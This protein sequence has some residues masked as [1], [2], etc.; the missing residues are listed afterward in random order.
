MIILGLNAY[1]GDA[2]ACIMKDGKILFALEE[3]RIRRVKHW[4]GLPTEA[5]KACLAFTQIEFT[6]IDV[7]TISRDPKAKLFEKIKFAA[8]KI[9]SLKSIKN[10]SNNAFTISTLKEDILKSLGLN[11]AKAKVVFV[12]HHRCHLASSFYVSPFQKSALL[13][14]DGFGDFSS[15][16]WGIGEGVNINVEDSISYPHSLGVFYSTMTQLLGFDHFGDEYKVMGLAAYGEAKYLDRLLKIIQLKKVG[17]FQLEGKYFKHFS[18]GIKLQTDNEAPKISQL[19][20]EELQSL[21]AD[22][23]LDKELNQHHKDLA[24]STQVL[25]E[26]VI[27]EMA[28]NL[29]K[30]TGEKNLC[31]SGGVAQNSVAN[32]KLLK[33]TSFENIY[34]PPASYD[35]G[36]A[37]GSA[38]FY[39]HQI[40]GNSFSPNGHFKATLGPQFSN[41]EIIDQAQQMGLSFEELPFELINEKVTDCIAEGGVVGWFQG[42]TEF[43]PRALGNRSILADPRRKDIR[44]ILNLKIKN[45]ELFRPF[46]VSV[47]E[48]KIEDYFHEAIAS[49]YMERVF[50]VQENHKN[51]IPAATHADG[52]CRIQT[53]SQKEHPTFHN[54]ISLFHKKTKIPMLINT[55]F[56]QKEPIVN[57]PFD[58]LNCFVRT[59]MDMIVLENILIKR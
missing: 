39:H 22:L 38:L 44:E 27:F 17:G 20:T 59:K 5:I 33:A 29:Y 24:K 32:G 30:Q 8:T 46:A 15:T 50:K 49:P 47:L 56:N 43:G 55:S 9:F 54:L 6:D 18:E 52:S 7:I 42:R 57:T 23:K 12:E 13:S 37:I 35:A 31:L 36:T 10:R 28:E 2:A 16:M 1:H 34:I 40:L 51:T 11:H 26:E 53:V 4:A 41:K 58:A 25:A 19:F 48:E 45:R 3:E 21:F 14:I